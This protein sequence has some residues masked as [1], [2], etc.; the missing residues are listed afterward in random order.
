MSGLEVVFPGLLTTVQ[1]LGRAG[2]AHLGVP[3][4]GAADLISHRRANALVG[5]RPEAATLE[6][7][8]LGCRLRATAPLVVAIAGARCAVFAGG[9]PAPWG[10]PFRLRVGQVLE[11]GPADSGLRAYVAIRG[12]VAIEP[13]LGSRSTDVLSQ[14]GPA[15]LR[16]GDHLPVGEA[17][18]AAPE[19][20]SAAPDRTRGVPPPEGVIFPGP[21]GVATLEIEL[22]PRADWLG[23]TGWRRL[24]AQPWR[25]SEQS[26]RIGVRLEGEPLTRAR[27]RELPSE[28]LIRGAVQLP[29]SGL[30]L[31]FLA[32]H[33]TTGG[34]PVVALVRESSLAALGQLRPGEE[35]W[36]SGSRSR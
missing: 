6:T 34:Y 25:V 36:L 31:I 17:P 5:N 13:V 18:P 1:D 30:P 7:T 28:G 10:K 2:Y 19:L 15:P 21:H 12:G 32:D 4:S 20:F 14:L 11:V 24:L 3:R 26:N 27:T 22:G 8:L 35:L 16:P 29:P 33:P 9:V 23:E